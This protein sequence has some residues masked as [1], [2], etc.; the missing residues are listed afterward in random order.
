MALQD[1][2]ILQALSELTADPTTGERKKTLADFPVEVQTELHPYIIG[3]KTIEV[4]D[5][6]ETLPEP[7]PTPDPTPDP[8]PTPEPEVVAAA[9]RQEV[10]VAKNRLTQARAREDKFSA[11]IAEQNAIIA[12]PEPD[13][14]MDEDAWDAWRAKREAA[15]NKKSDIALEYASSRDVEEIE[16]TDRFVAKS[17]VSETIES[18][19]AEFETLKL[20]QPFEKMAA[21]YTDWQKKAIAE[22]GQADLQVAFQRFQKDPE[23]AAKVGALPVGWEKLFVYLHAIEAQKKNGGSLDGHIL[24]YARQGGFLKKIRETDASRAAADAEAARLE[25]AR[26]NDAAL[27]AR[28]TGA[29]PASVTTGTSKTPEPPAGRPI[30]GNRDSARAWMA[31]W[32]KLAKQRPQNP[33]AAQ[34]SQYEIEDAW[35]E[36]AQ[37]IMAGSP[38]NAPLAIR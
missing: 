3:E 22:S 29:K 9:A 35:L 7:E 30:P 19:G 32:Q 38:D 5:E 17:A 21:Q 24:S 13:R 11:L 36:E 28:S 14:I 31:Q 15:I 23:F 8:E 1:S 12:E 18:I 6:P 37:N 33:T 2:E 27:H 25:V 10:E 16:E 20:E 4:A 34:R 26:R